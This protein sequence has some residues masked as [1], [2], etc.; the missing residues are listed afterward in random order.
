MFRFCP[1]FVTVYRRTDFSFALLDKHGLVTRRH[2]PK[3]QATLAAPPRHD[4]PLVKARGAS[5]PPSLTVQEQMRT[6]GYSPQ[7]P[8]ANLG[9]LACR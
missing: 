8:W 4:L 7:T 1:L 2:N 9:V 3:Q 5:A 6:A